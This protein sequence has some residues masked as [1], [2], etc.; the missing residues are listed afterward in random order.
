[1]T[2]YETPPKMVKG[3]VGKIDTQMLFD[4]G[5]NRSVV[6]SKFVAKYEYLGKTAKV[7]GFRGEAECTQMSH[8]WIHVREF[9][10]P[11]TVLVDDQSKREVLIGSDIDP[12]LDTLLV[13]NMIDTYIKT[14]VPINALKYGGGGGVGKQMQ[15]S[16]EEDKVVQEKDVE[17]EEE[18]ANMMVTRE[19]EKKGKVAQK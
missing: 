14:S 6:H 19:V 17:V 1:M 2:P 16:G 4:T 8:V 10:I 7:R 18:V 12:T 13:Q 3:M 5:A 11:D 9:S 15:E